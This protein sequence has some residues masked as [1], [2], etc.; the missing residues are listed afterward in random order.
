[1]NALVLMTAFV[2][3][4]ELRGGGGGEMLRNDFLLQHE[5]QM[6]IY[7]ETITAIKR[8]PVKRER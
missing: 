2:V 6:L 4:V 7:E 1:L 5:T 8:K 3:G